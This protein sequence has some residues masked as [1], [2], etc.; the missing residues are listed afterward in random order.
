MKTI[1]LILFLAFSTPLFAQNDTLII[2]NDY[3]WKVGVKGLLEKSKAYTYNDKIVNYGVNLIYAINKNGSL[4]L[5]TGLF[6][7][8]RVFSLDYSENY[9]SKPYLL[10]FNRYNIDIPINFMVRKKVFNKIF[11][12]SSFG[13]YA[14]YNLKNFRVSNDNIFYNKVQMNKFVIGYNFNFG[15]EKEISNHLSI[16]IDF[17]TSKNISPIL[18]DD[19]Y[20]MLLIR[21]HPYQNYGIGIGINYKIYK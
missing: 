20:Y 12:Y 16:T 8:K 21:N 5:E 6:F 15:I 10:A 1:I 2:N 18:K 14:E 11:L 3:K 4:N 9:K 19:L 7:I 17:E 13:L